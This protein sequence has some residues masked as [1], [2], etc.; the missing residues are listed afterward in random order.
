MPPFFFDTDRYLSG[1]V[2]A[3][4]TSGGP[5]DG[6]LTLKATIRPAKGYI[7]TYTNEIPIVEKY[8]NFVSILLSIFPLIYKVLN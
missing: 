8:F 7:S 4:Y 5:V 2:M 1:F 6:N 3:N